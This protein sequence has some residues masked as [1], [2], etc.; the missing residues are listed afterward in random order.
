MISNHLVE[1]AEQQG[2]VK[3]THCLHNPYGD[4]K[5]TLGG[6]YDLHFLKTAAH[7]RFPS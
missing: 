2:T 7:G 4:D 6:K 5:W 1:L 3:A